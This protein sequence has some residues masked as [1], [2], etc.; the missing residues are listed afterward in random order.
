MTE[1]NNTQ[2]NPKTDPTNASEEAI[3]N[4]VFGSEGDD[5]FNQLEDSVN[6]MVAD[7]PTPKAQPAMATQNESGS[8]QVTH[9]SQT[10]SKEGDNWERRYKDSSKEAIKMATQLK[11]LEPFIPV[12]D[13][14]KK[15]SG[16]VD[17]VRSYLENG[18]APA[19]DIKQQ[20]NL[21]D[22]FEFDANEA[23]ANPDSDSAKVMSAHLDK[24]VN[25]R[26]GSILNKEKENSRKIQAELVRRK[27]EE[28]FR[29][30]HNM[31]TEE[32]NSMVAN[33][34]QRKLTLDDVYYLLNKDKAAANA[35]NSSKQDMLNQMKNVRDIPTSA[36]DS[37]SQGQSKSNSDSLFDSMLNLDSGTDNLFG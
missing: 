35:V 25:S 14:M 9:E 20:L 16:L 33:A 34:K 6:G 26:V 19:G 28:S 7:K 1:E 37:N 4:E 30:K 3:N 10:G 31:S 21:K 15:D 17:H 32:F 5:F 13:A 18:G 22:D 2:G 8:E 29:Q 11:Q 36:S 12:L 23:Y 24:V 27:Q